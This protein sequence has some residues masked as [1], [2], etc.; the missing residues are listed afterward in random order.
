MNETFMEKVTNHWRIIFFPS[1]SFDSKKYLAFKFKLI[2]QY[3]IYCFTV[4]YLT[5][6]FLKYSRKFILI[7]Q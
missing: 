3:L 1:L 4:K 6:I 5:S 2:E 7:F